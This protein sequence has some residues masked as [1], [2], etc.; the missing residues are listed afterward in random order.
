[1]ITFHRNTHR[2]TTF[3]MTHLRGREFA[4]DSLLEQ[5]GFELMVPLAE[6]VPRLSL[7]ETEAFAGRNRADLGGRGTGKA[8]EQPHALRKR[9]T[10]RHPD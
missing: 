7:F 1:M 2:N 3:A 4:Q 10:T 6:N 9:T 5:S 8:E